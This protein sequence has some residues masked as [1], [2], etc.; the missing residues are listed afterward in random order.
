MTTFN[1]PT[2]QQLQNLVKDDDRLLK[3][4][5]ELFRSSGQILPNDITSIEGAIQDGVISALQMGRIGSLIDQK[6][7][8]IRS[9]KLGQIVFVSDK[10]DFPAAVSGVITLLDN[11]TY[12]VTADV[13]L[14]GDR[15]IGAANTVFMGSSPEN[16]KLTSTGLVGALITSDKTMSL[17]NIGFY[18][19]H[20]YDL[21]GSIGQ[22]ID[23]YKVNFVNCPTIGNMEDYDNAIFD[24]LGILNS[25]NMSFDGT[26][27]TIGFENTIFLGVP[28]ETTIIFPSSATVTRRFR[29]IY[30]ALIA[31]AATSTAIE[32]SPSAT[33]P[34]EGYILDSCNF[35]GGGTFIDGV[36]YDDNKAMFSN[37]IG[38]NNSTEVANYYMIGNATV[39]P[40][41]S[42]TPTKILGT[43]TD[44]PITQRF[45]HSN[46]RMTYT[47]GVAR[48][49]QVTATAALSSN[50]NN[51]LALFVAKNGTVINQSRGLGT[52]NA[53]GRAEGLSSN[54]LVELQ[55][56][57]YIEMYVDNLTG[58][59]NVVDIDLNVIIGV[60][61]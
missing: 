27:G 42:G 1:P 26:I 52:A 15:F 28:N 39:T 8:D 7:D 31:G 17:F 6:L 13:D 19:V 57:D 5:E 2:R 59:N 46:N 53:G 44:D 47:G 25:A 18:D 12:F 24:T 4:F 43:T 23:W 45:T 50:N 58:S 3:L 14:E 10:Y 30:S 37:N 38:I 55:E 20:V 21:S 29:I 16:C 51:E 9:L 61:K 40:T 60:F 11:V 33:I 54:A 56:N 34:I 48:I 41:T 35:S 32:V 49:F 36:Q 22:A